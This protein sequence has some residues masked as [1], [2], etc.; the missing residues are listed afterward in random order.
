M[1]IPSMSFMNGIAILS[2]GVCWHMMLRLEWIAMAAEQRYEK[3]G[4]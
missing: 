3:C 1:V 4:L 2:M